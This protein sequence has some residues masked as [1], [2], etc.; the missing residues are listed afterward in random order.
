M[1]VNRIEGLGKG[2]A[3]RVQFPGCLNV[4][5]RKL[6]GNMM[7][8]EMPMLDHDLCGGAFPRRASHYQ[9]VNRNEG[10][11]RQRASTS[12]AV[13]IALQADLRI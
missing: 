3:I 8:V 7:G 11:D 2:H 10:G 12:I 5:V 9:S 4:S 1:A 6:L 13:V